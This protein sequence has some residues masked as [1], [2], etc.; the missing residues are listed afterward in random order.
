MRKYGTCCLCPLVLGALPMY[1]I[2][3]IFA[4]LYQDYLD[5]EP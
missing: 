3:S 1:F 5:V 2:Q 4:Y